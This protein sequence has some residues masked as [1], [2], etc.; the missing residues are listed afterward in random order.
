MIFQQDNI[1]DSAGNVLD[2]IPS[3]SQER[4]SV[5]LTE[6]PAGSSE[7]P[8][9]SDI[10]R[11]M[12]PDWILYFSIV[13]LAIIAWI[14]L[15]YTKFIVNIFKSSVNYQLSLKVYQEPGIIKK[16][17]F[18]FLNV[19]YL[20]TTGIL[21][22]L[23]FDYFKY[24]PLGYRNLKLLGIIIAFL[25]GYSLFRLMVMRITGTLFNRKKLFSLAIFQNLLYNKIGGIVLIPFILLIAYTRDIYQDISVYAGLAALITL[26]LLRL[27][28][29]FIFISKSVVLLFYFILYLCTLEIVPVL[30]I[31]KLIFSLSKG[32]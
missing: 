29:L 17:I 16:R 27:I 30:V 11:E 10:N 1:A 20:L 28:R 3:P 14:R 4:P 19:F 8:S 21:V 12:A 18:L 32:L 7:Y 9:S 22:Y 25:M 6:E 23:V 31:L 5:F 24:Y 15:I 13:I 26:N 2:T